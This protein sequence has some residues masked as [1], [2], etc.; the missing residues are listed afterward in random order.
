MDIGSGN[1]YWTY[2]LRRME[3]PS[4]KEKK[5]EVLP[6][7]N[8]VSEWRTVWVGDTL[9]T[10]GIKWLQQ[11]GGGKDDV[12]L[13]VYPTVGNDFTGK[14]LKAYSKCC[15]LLILNL[16]LLMCEIGGSTIICAGSQNA[17][18]FTAFNKETIADWIAREMPAWDKMLQ[19]PLPSFAGK[20]EAL[21]VFQKKD[22]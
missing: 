12:L 17:S 10:D 18:G 16:R 6:I 19:I 7:D 2:M 22:G 13:L 9:E 8:G 11:N 5:L 1:G 15:V 20:D 21:F 3:A 4:K 14:I